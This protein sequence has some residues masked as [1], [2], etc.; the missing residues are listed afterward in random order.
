MS[1]L[2]IAPALILIVA[3]G[4]AILNFTFTVTSASVTASETSVSVSGPATLTLSG[5][6]PDTGTFSASG[7]LANISGGNV[8]VPFTATLGHGTITGTVTFPETSLVSPGPASS[9]TT[10]TGGTDRYA[11][12]TS[13]T[14]PGSGLTG[15]LLSGGTLSFSVSG[16]A[17]TR[18]FT[19]TVTN[20][21]FTI[22]GTTVFS[23]P[24]T[25]AL[26]GSSPDTGTFSASGSLTNISGGN[27]TVPFTVTLVHGTVTG[28]VTFPETVLVNSGPFSASATITGGTSSYAG[29]T[30]TTLTASGTVTGSVLSGGTISFTTSGTVNTGGPIPPSI[31]DI[32]NNSS[33][34]PAGFP[35]S[36]IGPSSIFVIHGDGMASATTVTALQD[37][38]K[39][40]LPT[41]GGA[42]RRRR[43]RQCRRQDVHAGT[44]L[45]D[46]HANRRRHARRGPARS[47]DGD[48]QL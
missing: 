26:A 30:S 18:S 29:Y 32:E 9:S 15:P 24:A 44:L 31:T 42:Q 47:G 8:T 11:G 46:R 25:L 28:T 36:G 27:V 39:A 35:N 2:M 23:G 3:A 20:A 40:P 33:S 48:S 19:F 4:A 10:I 1:R 34:I 37:S 16:T 41:T 17:D 14:V 12:S 13:S 43:N 38:T 6:S 5:V 21:A 22:S 45:R 7:S